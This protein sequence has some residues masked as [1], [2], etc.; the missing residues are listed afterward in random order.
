M[1][2]KKFAL[3]AVCAGM[4]V[5][6]GK[7]PAAPDWS[8]QVKALFAEKLY[9]V[10]V[11]YFLT[12]AFGTLDIQPK[13][14]YGAV[15]IDGG[16]LASSESIKAAADLLK[17]YNF[18]DLYEDIRG[19]AQYPFATEWTY[20]MQLRLEVAE[21]GPRYVNV[22]LSGQLPAENSP[23]EEGEEPAEPQR[24]FHCEI[25]DPYLYTWTDSAT[26][27]L[28]AYSFGSLDGEG[29]HADETIASELASVAYI[30]QAT[31]L[32]DGNIYVTQAGDLYAPDIDSGL[33]QVA[34]YG[35]MR[36]FFDDIILEEL[37]SFAEDLELDHWKVK[38][39]EPGELEP[40]YLGRYYQL[41]SPS[42]YFSI[43]VYYSEGEAMF[44]VQLLPEYS[45]AIR[46]VA[47]LSKT[48]LYEYSLDEKS[49][50]YYA[51]FDV[52]DFEGTPSA[53]EIA[54]L[55]TAASAKAAFDLI[56]N[57]NATDVEVVDEFVTYS[58]YQGEGVL[59]V[60]DHQ[61]Y[62]SADY[63]YD[64]DY[65]TYTVTYYFFWTIQVSDWPE[66]PAFLTS[67]FA[68]AAGASNIH[69]FYEQKDGSLKFA[70]ES[71]TEEQALAAFNALSALDGA[72][73]LAEFSSATKIGRLQ[74]ADKMVV[75][76]YVV[77]QEETRYTAEEAAAYN[78]QHG[79]QEGDEGYVHEG[80]IKEEAVFGYTV[81]ITALPEIDAILKVVAPAIP[82]YSAFD[83]VKNGDDQV[84]YGP[85]EEETLGQTIFDN[86]KA[87]SS[88]EVE[89]NVL[90]DYS[91]DSD[92]KDGLGRL[93]VN[94]KQ[95]SVFVYLT[96]DE[97]LYFQVSVGELPVFPDVVNAAA[98]A[99]GLS[100]VYQFQFYSDYNEYIYFPAGVPEDFGAAAEAC[101]NK[102]AAIEGATVEEAFSYTAET[103]EAEA[104]MTGNIVIGEYH[105]YLDFASGGNFCVCIGNYIPEPAEHPYTLAVSQALGATEDAFEW[106]TSFALFSL[107]AEENGPAEVSKD[108]A[109][110][111]FSSISGAILGAFEGETFAASE[112]KESTEQGYI[113]EYTVYEIS[114]ES[115][116]FVITIVIDTMWLSIG[117]ADNSDVTIKIQP[118]TAA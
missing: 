9:G 26:S 47:E 61:V 80:D 29:Y 20:P 100:S 54:K 11:P 90:V 46:K 104:S 21:L 118:K 10:N 70:K 48:N 71:G 19:D 82:G 39:F 23:A 36:V 49:N 40:G 35:Y 4:L 79:L 97:E 7:T 13:S 110:A 34:Q 1:N 37:G 5:S 98:T 95:V 99:L 69:Q 109:S 91:Y 25:F 12:D 107:L 51:M 55:T 17:G 42:E 53:E 8:A 117:W 73:V 62:V 85:A 41:V 45:A 18:V 66:Y 106:D 115:E 43:D 102:L 74:F 94:D 31:Y 58:N 64:I 44:K 108:A 103:E 87:L 24:Y 22:S 60:A 28:I 2:Y 6:C 57:S 32:Y 30:G 83:F 86:L 93:Q 3:A 78:E 81:S 56:K 50:T 27:D 38:S 88:E 63:D 113:G 68:E 96:Q 92:A 77:E 67:A 16:K 72:S 84:V 15:V 76:Q 111:F 101:F 52:V 65:T 59:S 116:N 75:V 33:K 14:E 114:Y 105:I 89:V 112:I